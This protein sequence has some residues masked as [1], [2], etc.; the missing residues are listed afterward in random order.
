[1]EPCRYD[2]LVSMDDTI[3]RVQVKTTTVK[4][5]SSWTVWISSTGKTRTAYDPEEV[6]YFF[7]IDGDLDYYLIPVAVVGGLTA[8]QLSAY[9]NY[10]I[11]RDVR[12]G[13]YEAADG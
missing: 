4:Q 7:I 13:Q 8:I 12:R 11:D 3:K 9:Q 6:D 5:G 1:M 10:R 2:L